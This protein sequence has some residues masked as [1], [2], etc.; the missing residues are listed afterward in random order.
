M[1]Q[2]WAIT[3]KEW[4]GLRWKLAALTAIPVGCQLCLL[5]FDPTLISTS[6]ITLLVAYGAVAPIFLAMHAAAEDSSAGTLDFV[7]GLPVALF[8]V[9]IIRILATLAVLLVPLIVSAV[10]AWALRPFST[11]VDFAPGMPD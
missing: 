10:T 7:R 5:V 6:L 4:L 8:Q 1:R 11:L 9:G 2:I 3:W